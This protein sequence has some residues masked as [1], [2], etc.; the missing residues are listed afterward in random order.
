MDWRIEM[1]A[2]VLD[3]PPPVQ[4][5]PVLLEIELLLQF[6]AGHAE[7]RWEF[8]RHGVGQ[9]DHG[10]E[11]PPGRERTGGGLD[12]GGGGHDRRS[13]KARGG[14]TSEETAAA[15]RRV[16][17]LL[18]SWNTHDRLP[19]CG[20]TMAVVYLRPPFCGHHQT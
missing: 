9:I 7:K 11:G 4:I 10:L 3:D 6:D 14:R 19:A 13:G 1:G 2:G 5:E 16:Q 15:E 17:R 20:W 8:R 18:A 12:F